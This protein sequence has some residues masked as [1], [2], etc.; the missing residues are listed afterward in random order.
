MKWLQLGE[1]HFWVKMIYE[2]VKS[3]AIEQATRRIATV[4]STTQKLL[5]KFIPESTRKYRRDHLT[6]SNEKTRRRLAD[7]KREHK[8][9]I[10]YI[11]RNNEAKQLLCDE[12]ILVNSALFMYV[13]SIRF[14]LNIIMTIRTLYSYLN[15][16]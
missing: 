16:F 3:G 11:L 15:L 13:W 1:W 5:M 9:F 2:T 12:E 4:G 7:V 6:F 8:D 10:Y 14:I